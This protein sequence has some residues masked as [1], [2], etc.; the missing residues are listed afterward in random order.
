MRVN[1][2]LRGSAVFRCGSC[3]LT[4]YRQLNAAINLYLRMEGFPS[5]A[6]GG[7]ET[8]SRHWWACGRVGEYLLTGAERKDPDELVTGLHDALK[9]QLN[10]YEG[11]ADAYLWA[12][13]QSETP[14]L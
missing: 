13:A 4:L 11:Y 1:R 9:P 2:D 5:G 8:S 3:G 12:P 6:S 7:T 14:L 10:A